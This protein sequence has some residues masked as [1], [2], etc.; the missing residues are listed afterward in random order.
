VKQS[1]ETTHCNKNRGKELTSGCQASPQ[2][3]NQQNAYEH[4]RTHSI[5]HL[6]FTSYGKQAQ[7]PAGGRNETEYENGQVLYSLVDC[8]LLQ[9]YGTWTW[10][11]GGTM[12]SFGPF[13]KICGRFACADVG[14]VQC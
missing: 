2:P 5:I 10:P 13:S 9:L 8:P 3:Q 4:H 1:Q 11:H 7:S 14:V 12:P 6:L